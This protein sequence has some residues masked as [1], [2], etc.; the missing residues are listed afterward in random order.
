MDRMGKATQK[1]L[2]VTPVPHMGTCPSLLIQ[3]PAYTT[4]KTVYNVASASAPEPVW[5]IQEKLLASG[6]NLVQPQA[7]EPF[8]GVD[9]QMENS[10]CLSL[11]LSPSLSLFFSFSLQLCFSNKSINILKM[12]RM[13]V[14]A[15]S[16]TTQQGLCETG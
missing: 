9:K 1:L 8:G 14:K 5:E 12:C 10:P 13:G 2:S 3:L 4:G 15:P 16:R 6:F 7:L 11:S